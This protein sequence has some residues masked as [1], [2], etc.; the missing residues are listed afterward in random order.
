MF[1]KKDEAK[2]EGDS[3]VLI[4]LLRCTALLG[5]TF[6]LGCPPCVWDNF[7]VA[8]YSLF[9]LP[10]VIFSC[11]NSEPTI[12]PVSLFTSGF[13]ELLCCLM[14][15][16]YKNQG[17]VFGSWSWLALAHKS[18]SCASLLNSARQ[19]VIYHSDC[20]YA[21]EIGDLGRLTDQ[22]VCVRV[23]V[24]VPAP[25]LLLH[26]YQALHWSKHQNSSS[27]L[28]SMLVTSH[29]WLFTSKLK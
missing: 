22:G 14:C 9:L 18:Q 28:A 4:Y 1:L 20:I 26:I 24:D 25:A 19:F 6:C 23:C 17:L 29:L 11:L 15:F 16:S 5:F 10:R 21:M 3:S 13:S 12:N 27:V 8:T 7:A 2:L